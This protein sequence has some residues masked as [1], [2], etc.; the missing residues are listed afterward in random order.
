[1]IPISDDNPV[2]R[3]PYV[4]YAILAVTFAVWLL[5]EGAGF[6]P[7]LLATR[8]CD[9][10]LVPAELTHRLPVGAGVP[11][12]RG[13]YCVVDDY[14]INYLT[15]ITSIFLHGGWGHILGNALFLWVFGNNIEDSM[16]RGRFLAFYLLCGVAAAAAHVLVEPASP[17]PTVGASGAISGVLGAY[18]VLYPRVR[19]RV[20][21][22]IFIF[23]TIV[24]VPAWVTLLLWFGYQVIAGLPQLMVVNRE[25]SGGVAVWAHIGGFVAGAALIKLFENPALVRRRATVGDARAVWGE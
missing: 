17:I 13:L 21:L 18:L 16:G 20:L 25:V 4:T 12:G 19:V 1:M 5:V 15:P 14:T 3:T 6:D 9:Y 11:I 23:F 10:G 8:V 2:L 24:R 22:P 7:V